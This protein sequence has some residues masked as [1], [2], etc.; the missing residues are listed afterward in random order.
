MKTITLQDIKR[1]G[2]K[3]LKKGSPLYLIVN[4]KPQSVI[5]SVED[6]ETLIEAIEDYEDMLVIEER[7]NDPTVTLEEAFQEIEK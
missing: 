4:S 1:F 5:L 2:S 3:A 6:Y 7:K